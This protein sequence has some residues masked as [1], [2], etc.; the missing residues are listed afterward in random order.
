MNV[1]KLRSSILIFVSLY[2]S[3]FICVNPN[4]HFDDTRLPFEAV[5]D[6]IS[7]E[8]I[9]SLRNMLTNEHEKQ[10][11][12]HGWYSLLLN[13]LDKS[14]VNSE[15]EAK[16]I[17]KNQY[18]KELLEILY[19]L[20]N[21]STFRCLDKTLRNRAEEN[22]QHELLYNLVFSICD[23]FDIYDP[24]VRNYDKH[25]PNSELYKLILFQLLEK[26]LEKLSTYND[27]QVYEIIGLKSLSMPNTQVSEM[28]SKLHESLKKTQ[29]LRDALKTMKQSSDS[30]DK[31][32]RY[33]DSINQ[34]IQ[35][36]EKMK[37]MKE[38][39]DK[40]YGCKKCLSGI[41][42]DINIYNRMNKERNEDDKI[43]CIKRQHQND[44]SGL[45]KEKVEEQKVLEKEIIELKKLSSKEQTDREKSFRY[46]AANKKFNYTQLLNLIKLAQCINIQEHI[47][48]D[49]KQSIIENLEPSCIAQ[50]IEVENKLKAN[51]LNFNQDLCL[52]N[53]C[54]GGC[55]ILCIFGLSYL[56]CCYGIRVI[57]RYK[58]TNL[59]NN[60][61]LIYNIYDDTIL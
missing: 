33:Y 40:I 53:Y 54:A 18:K 13:I 8:Q 15:I 4:L 30:L 48:E 61:Q 37:L 22:T 25:K 52:K 10:N 41:N 1:Y 11:L 17:L 29:E 39:S 27:S 38:I 23:I 6:C 55:S 58:R 59:L 20:L 9:K 24:Q 16:Q 44:Y 5:S 45:I 60:M 21:K 49:V 35:L 31:T 2:T 50:Y 47:T 42:A 28:I 56:I 32:Y 14:T 36:S 26:T 43:L 19:I 34:Q 3:N 57:R 12:Q 46:I 51:I 7:T